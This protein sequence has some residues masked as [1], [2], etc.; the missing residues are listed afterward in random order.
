[1]QRVEVAALR[2]AVFV[3]LE[4][5]VDRPAGRVGDQAGRQA[6]HLGEVHDG[7]GLVALSEPRQ[8]LDQ[9]AKGPVVEVVRYRLAEAAA[10]REASLGVF[11]V[12]TAN[13]TAKRTV[14]SLQ[15]ARAEMERV[16]REEAPPFIWRVAK[17]GS[18]KPLG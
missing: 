11:V 12:I 18:L 16:A 14:E 6:L 17:D 2:V 10:L 9:E 1:V 15:K 13:L 3:P 7:L 8:A 5:R 4:G